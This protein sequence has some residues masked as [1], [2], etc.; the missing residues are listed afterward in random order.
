MSEYIKVPKG[1]LKN[2]LKHAVFAVFYCKDGT[3][4]KKYLDKDSGIDTIPLVLLQMRRENTIGFPGG[5]VDKNDAS[6]G[7]LTDDILKR[8]LLRELKE[9]LNYSSLDISK[10]ERLSTYRNEEYFLHSYMYEV[11]KDEMREIICTSTTAA[12]FLVESTGCF[13]F[14]LV[15]YSE[16]DKGLKNLKRHNFCASTYLELMDLIAHLGITE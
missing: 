7:V 10:F 8:A 16:K 5:K 4:Y 15:N 14:Q 13:A 9:E 1:S 11:T 12:N 3:P 6:D 2:G